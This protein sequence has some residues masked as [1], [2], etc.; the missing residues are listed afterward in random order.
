M[1]YFRHIRMHIE[2]DED[3]V[4]RIDEVAGMRHR[5]QF[6]RDAVAA[7]LEHRARAGL[8]RAA[9]GTIAD[10]SHEWDND[11]AAWVRKQRKADDR[12]LG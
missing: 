3:L 7:A 6:V 1:C 4:H 5:S 10:G 8:I 12:R 9:R 11:P 2:I